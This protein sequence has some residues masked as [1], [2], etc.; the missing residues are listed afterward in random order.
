[1]TTVALRVVPRSAPEPVRWPPTPVARPALELSQPPLPWSAEPA[2]TPRSTAANRAARPPVHTVCFGTGVQ[3]GL[4]DPAD[5]AV[6]L[7]RM[8]LETMHGL[9]PVNQLSRWVEPQ[10]L[11]ELTFRS[12]RRDRSERT[13]L[14]AVHLHQISPLAAEVVAVHRDG[15]GRSGALAFRLEGAGDRWI[16]SALTTGP[17]PQPTQAAS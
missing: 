6:R 7:A 12:R 1:M 11:S 9:R 17:Q 10:I 16:C 5:W 4:P 13:A 3:P 2:P 15:T 14:T 8:V